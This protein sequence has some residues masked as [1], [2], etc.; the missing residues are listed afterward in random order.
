MEDIATAAGVTRGLVYSYFPG[1]DGLGTKDQLYLA[2]LERA[3]RELE[4]R[5][6]VAALAHDE[7]RDRLQAGI[8]AYFE[9][10]RDSGQRWDLLF[11]GGTAV[12]GTVATQYRALRFGTVE[13]IAV[14]LEVSAPGLTAQQAMPFAHLMSGAIEQL[15][16]WWRDQP[17]VPLDEVAD[18]ALDLLWTGFSSHA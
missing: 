16:Q 6:T 12:A 10:V 13:R 7:A 5:F 11:G 18:R 14:L 17:E 3:R 4:E 9:F 15:A 2:C 1:A 8:T